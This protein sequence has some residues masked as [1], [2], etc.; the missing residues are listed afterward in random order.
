MR[1]TPSHFGLCVHDLARSLRF[2]CDG[3]GF[4]VAERFEIGDEFGAA[5]EVEGRVD[6]ISQFIRKD[7]LAIELLAYRSPGAIG[8]PPTRRNQLGL[9]HVSLYVDDVASAASHLVACGGKL[10]PATHAENDAV[11]LLFV[12]DPDGARVELIRNK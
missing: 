5:L 2:W 1:F 12:E 3:L 7:A 6:C 10:L 8:A 11:E 4:A 9:T